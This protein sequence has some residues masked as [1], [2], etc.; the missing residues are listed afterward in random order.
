MSN[1][2]YLLKKLLRL[3]DGRSSKWYRAE[4]FMDLAKH[5]NLQQAIPSS[6]N[7][8]SKRF[9]SSPPN[10]L[11]NEVYLALV[12]L[13]QIRAE[14]GLNPVQY[15]ANLSAYAQQRAQEIIQLFDHTRPNGQSYHQEVS[16][17]SAENIAAG[18]ETGQKVILSWKNSAGHYRNMMGNYQKA[19][20]GLVY[21]PQSQYQYYW[22]LI[23]G[24]KDSSTPYQ[25]QN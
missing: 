25:F 2:F 15:D 11:Y 24:G 1:L 20:I 13:N 18:Q 3:F 5:L 12:H 17:P 19:G 23:M 6:F 8:L 7:P 22:V 21:Q 4:Q 14:R 9:V 10:H 16:P